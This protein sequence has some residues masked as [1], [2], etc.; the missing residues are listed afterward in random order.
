MLL[1]E[2][3]SLGEYGLVGRHKQSTSLEASHELYPR[4]DRQGWFSIYFYVRDHH[5]CSA[6]VRA[7]GIRLYTSTHT[8]TG[9]ISSAPSG[10]QSFEPVTR[11]SS[12]IRCNSPWSLVQN[13]TRHSE[14][15]SY[16]SFFRL[17]VALVSL[18]APHLQGD[19]LAV[20]IS[21]S[22]S[23]Y[24]ERR[25]ASQGLCWSVRDGQLALNRLTGCLFRV[26]LGQ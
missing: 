25:S 24:T 19:W 8:E 7:C 20:T 13:A 11:Q 14:P 26:R 16:D 2:S 9:L 5:L 23:L 15:L 4:F 17:C 22:L 18:V 10:R 21:F 12:G 3:Y 6:S 1:L